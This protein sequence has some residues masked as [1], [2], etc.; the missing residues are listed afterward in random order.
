VSGVQTGDEEGRM[1]QN[2]KNHNLPPSRGPEALGGTSPGRS[3]AWTPGPWLAIELG[4]WLWCV[5]AVKFFAWRLKRED[6]QL[7]AAAPE[8]YVA[9]KNTEAAL[10]IAVTRGIRDLYDTPEEIAAAVAEHSIIKPARAALAKAR[11]EA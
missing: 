11:G 10:T 6:A 9:L 1:N 3:E 7:M 5:K 2:A 4:G 8:L